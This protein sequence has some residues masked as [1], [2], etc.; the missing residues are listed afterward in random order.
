M[1]STLEESISSGDEVMRAAGELTATAQEAGELA[2]SVAI[3]H[4][5]VKGWLKTI[6]QAVFEVLK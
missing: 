2:T 1:S 3:D 5:E 4:E 6:F